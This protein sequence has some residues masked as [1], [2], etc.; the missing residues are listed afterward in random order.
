[1]N[2]QAKTIEYERTASEQ[3]YSDNI[4][5][6]V[7]N[8]FGNSRF[9]RMLNGRY[10][11]YADIDGTAVGVVLATYNED[12]ANYA[13]NRTEL[14]RLLKGKASGKISAA[15]VVMAKLQGQSRT[16]VGIADAEKLYAKL[17]S[18]PAR[19]GPYG[20]FWAAESFS[21]EEEPF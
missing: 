18:I 20:E 17:Q 16:V 3:A 10:L 19:T 9:R 15:Y 7:L 14:E 8:M 21:D 5:R 13:L 2:D 12:F 11:Y 4:S 6:A 1:M